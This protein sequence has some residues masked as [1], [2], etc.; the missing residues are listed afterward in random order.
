M[1]TLHKLLAA[2]CLLTSTTAAQ[3]AR[4]A[5][6]AQPSQ[7]VMVRLAADDLPDAQDVRSDRRRQ[8]LARRQADVL[9]RLPA[10][11]RGTARSYKYS[12]WL[13]LNADAATLA[14]LNRDGNVISVVPDSLIAPA[15]GVSVPLIEADLTAANG[16]DGSGTAIAILDTGVDA[17]HPMLAGRVAFQACT[18]GLDCVFGEAMG[19]PAAPCVGVQAGVEG[20][21]HGTHVAGIA[22]GDGSSAGM[23]SGV[24]PG[25]DILA[26]QV[27]HRTDDC[28]DDPAPC[29]RSRSSAQLAALEQVFD[30][31]ASG[32][33]IAAVNM[34]IGGGISLTSCGD[35]PLTGMVLAL[36][37]LDVPVVISAG[38]DNFALGVSAPSCI[39]LAVTV[40]ATTK[41]DDVWIDPPHGSNGGLQLDLFAPGANIQSSVT[42]GAHLLGHM[43]GTSMAAPHVAGAFAALRHAV[44]ERNFM[45]HLSAL[46]A[47][48]VPITDPRN[49]LTTPRID[50]AAAMASFG[51]E[52]EPC[53]LQGDVDTDGDG[54]CDGD[55]NCPLVANASQSDNDADGVGNVCDNCAATPNAAQADFDGDGLG[56]ACDN[57]IDND[58]CGN[59]SDDDPD[60]AW[61]RSGR[62]V[63]LDGG[64]GGNTYVW[65]G[66]NNGEDRLRHCQDSDDDND[67]VLDV[68]D[69][70]PMV[71]GVDPITCLEY[72]MCHGAPVEGTAWDVCQL[73]LCSQVFLLEAEVSNPDPTR[74]QAL[75][76]GV[77]VVYVE[78]LTA[79][80]AAV[81]DLLT[82][83]RRTRFSRAQ[84]LVLQARDVQDNPL[85]LAA[86]DPAQVT[87][88]A[89]RGDVVAIHVSPD[90][91]GVAL[92][93]R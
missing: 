67:G 92:S 87:V 12:P 42:G 62:Y 65:A 58:G 37:T 23:L 86:F 21:D 9:G 64:A 70:C 90:R 83:A 50:V 20:C 77:D 43:S 35:D 8:A 27:F 57:D 18:S 74:L 69:P 30:L 60:N 17:T 63:C 39:P 78:A 10:A 38:N 75:G 47:T 84:Q 48:G 26:F 45:E 55:D 54:L 73:G 93:G 85:T 24:A 22:A 51:V 1:K 68:D 29:L 19:A 91:G 40:G 5:P 72:R 79:D 15:L 71:P 16:F 44:P 11:A 6:P 25:A 56:D 66:G 4:P 7:A 14:A 32:W 3:A 81:V 46:Q 34:S 53:A 41:G 89:L 13:A 36:A 31:R 80:G 61:A 76:F 33:N 82:G 2:A 88:Q 59:G 52:L 28:G 49:G